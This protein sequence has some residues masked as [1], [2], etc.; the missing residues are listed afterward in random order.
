M[1][2][3]NDLLKFAKRG[4][5]DAVLDS[6]ES[7]ANINFQDDRGDNLLLYAAMQSRWDIVQTLLEKGHSPYFVNDCGETPLSYANSAE[8]VRLLAK[9][10]IN[11]SAKGGFQLPLSRLI[12][13]RDCE[14][15]SSYLF[16]WGH[17]VNSP[18]KKVAE[19]ILE[20][21]DFEMFG[22]YTREYLEEY[23]I[24]QIIRSNLPRKRRAVIKQILSRRI[25]P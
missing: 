13:N 2:N 25:F 19:I 22:A 20:S 11:P 7:G 12:A 15:V 21:Y 1:C 17:P 14:A 24:D 6:L 3:N 18:S 4:N 23:E 5:W 10:N 9:Y 16:H 8:A